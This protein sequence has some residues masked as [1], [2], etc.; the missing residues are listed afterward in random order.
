MLGTLYCMAPP[1]AHYH[2]TFNLSTYLAVEAWGGWMAPARVHT[3]LHGQQ[4][5]AYALPG[6]YMLQRCAPAFECP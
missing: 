6:I 4:I 1:A 2:P 5:D 3:Q